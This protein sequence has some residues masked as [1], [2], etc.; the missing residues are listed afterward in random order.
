MTQPGSVDAFV[1]TR[2]P[3]LD[4]VH[5]CN[6]LMPLT[7]R[8]TGLVIAWEP[9]DPWEPIQ[10]WF[11]YGVLPKPAIPEPIRQQLEGPNP[12]DKGHPCFG[13]NQYGTWCLCPAPKMRWAG[14]ESPLITRQAWQLYRKY[15]GWARPLWVVQG[16]NGGHKYRYTD[17]ESRLARLAGAPPRPPI[18]GELPYAEPDERTWDNLR[19][20][21]DPV[22]RTA[23]RGLV[24]FGMRRPGDLDPTDKRAAEFAAMQ[25]L[26]SFGLKVSEHADELAWAM[27]R[28][29]V[30]TALMDDVPEDT[31]AGMDAIQQELADT[32][33]ETL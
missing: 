10:R 14:G 25:T 16:D 4:W 18:A 13:K 31:E 7:D 22:L 2:K 23:Y 30:R 6:D 5:R 19:F 21:V 27:R 1:W 32:F 28:S 33:K 12:R 15:G 8:T 24:D 9:G 3:K 11:V 17:W 26:K 20:F 29:D